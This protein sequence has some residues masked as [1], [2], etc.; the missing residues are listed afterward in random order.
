MRHV[1]G[2]EMRS[3]QC[4]NGSRAEQMRS[5]PP[6]AACCGVC[7]GICDHFACRTVNIPVKRPCKPHKPHK[8]VIFSLRDPESGCVLLP[9]G[10]PTVSQNGLLRARAR[11][12]YWV[13]RW[14]MTGGYWEPGGYTGWVIPGPGTHPLRCAP[15]PASL[16]PSGPSSQQRPA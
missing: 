4:Q 12:R 14:C 3:K 7:G 15:G 16:V 2:Q 6:G 8:T 11:C 1:G 10:S 13:H 5:R 9:L